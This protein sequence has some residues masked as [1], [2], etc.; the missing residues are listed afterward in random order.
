[1]SQA[2]LHGLASDVMQAT[3]I[4]C[5]LNIQALFHSLF[6][7]QFLYNH[8]NARLISSIAVPLSDYVTYYTSNAQLFLLPQFQYILRRL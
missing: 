2:I 7:L 8:T 4:T 5:H 3:T 1:M 6:Y